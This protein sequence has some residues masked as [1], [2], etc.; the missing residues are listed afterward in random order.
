MTGGRVVQR[1]LILPIWRCRSGSS[2]RRPVG[3]GGDSNSVSC[4]F[5]TLGAFFCNIP[6]PRLDLLGSVCVVRVRAAKAIRHDGR[7]YPVASPNRRVALAGSSPSI[8]FSRT[9]SNSPPRAQTSRLLRH[10]EKEA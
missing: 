3:R 9:Y 5:K 2:S 1:A 4:G 10:G 6:L 8:S 7:A